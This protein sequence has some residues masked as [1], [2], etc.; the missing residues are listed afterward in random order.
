M[1]EPSSGPHEERPRAHDEAPS[2]ESPAA[3][4]VELDIDKEK[5]D[6]WD[7]VKSDYQVE[8]DGQPSPN[9]MDAP[10]PRSV[11]ADDDDR[12]GA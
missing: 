11:G 1:T 7:E 8:P 3:D 10:M 9:S 4:S 12:G 5:L 6:A 2:S